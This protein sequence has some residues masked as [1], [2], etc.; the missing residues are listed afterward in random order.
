MQTPPA[1]T[2]GFLLAVGVGTPLG[3]GPKALLPFRRRTLV[4]A[5]AGKLRSGGCAEATVVLGAGTE[6]A[7]GSPG[8]TAAI[9]SRTRGGGTAWA[10]PSR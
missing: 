3:R 5:L 1:P 6:E 2:T 10:A 9:S 4:E 7:G 8:A